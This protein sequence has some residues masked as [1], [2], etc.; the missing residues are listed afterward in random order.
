MDGSAA[1]YVVNTSS[2]VKHVYLYICLN[3]QLVAPC[4]QSLPPSIP[5]G[6]S[7]GLILRPSMSEGGR[8]AA[9]VG[10]GLGGSG[11]HE[12]EMFDDDAGAIPFDLEEIEIERLRRAPAEAMAGGGEDAL[13]ALLGR[14]SGAD[15]RPSLSLSA[16]KSNGILGGDAM[17]A[18]GEAGQGSPSSGLGGGSRERESLGA[19]GG[20][21][22]DARRR[23][24]AAAGRVAGAESRAGTPGKLGALLPDLGMDLDLEIGEGALDWELDLGGDEEQGPGEATAAQRAASA[25]GSG[26]GGRAPTAEEIRAAAIALAEAQQRDPFELPPDEEELAAERGEAAGVVGPADGEA[27]VAAE[28]EGT[29]DGAAAAADAAEVDDMEAPRRRGRREVAALQGDDAGADAVAAQEVGQEGRRLTRRQRQQLADQQQQQQSAEPAGT[30]PERAEGVAPAET[31]GAPADTARG[32]AMGG[33]EVAVGDEDAMD[34]DMLTEGG[35]VGAGQAEAGPAGAPEAMELDHGAAGRSPAGVNA[36]PAMSGGRSQPSAG[37]GGGTGGAAW[38]GG[39]ESGLQ[40]SEQMGQGGGGKGG[41]QQERAPVGTPAVQGPAVRSA[42]MGTGPAMATRGGRAAAAVAAAA[43]A[44]GG[45]PVVGT[46]GAAV[47]HA[48]VAE[49]QPAGGDDGRTAAKAGGQKAAKGVKAA[50]AKLAGGASK[51]ARKG[52]SVTVDTTGWC[53]A[54]KATCGSTT[55]VGVAYGTCS[56]LSN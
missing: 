7:L 56:L 11:D 39:S 6:Y 27:Q 4:L 16:A 37:S 5:Q 22:R 47:P 26:R 23:S 41:Q 19:S 21:A 46:E 12:M 53:D 54:R 34:V 29:V 50:A 8:G 25:G 42:S 3:T 43:A 30:E 9:S 2:T 49:G 15:G 17:E 13:A 44:A 10:G 20:A 18:Q 24:T 45:M 48:E 31:L 28:D 1:T 33:A 51:V 55:S 14:R 38:G 52:G 35:M 36:A 40:G 32:A